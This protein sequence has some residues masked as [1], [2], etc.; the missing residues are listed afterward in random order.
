MPEEVFVYL[1]AHRDEIMKAAES[2]DRLAVDIITFH[3]MYIDCAEAGSLGML[4]A[5]VG[6]WKRSK[7]AK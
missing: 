3:R 1:M 7:E 2:G 6:D 4:Q 5:A